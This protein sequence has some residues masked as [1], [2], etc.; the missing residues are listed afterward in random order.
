MFLTTTETEVLKAILTRLVS[1]E[2][3]NVVSS[4]SSAKNTREQKKK[5]AA[6]ELSKTLGPKFLNYCK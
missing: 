6:L 2:V 5:A 4:K 3:S 1:K